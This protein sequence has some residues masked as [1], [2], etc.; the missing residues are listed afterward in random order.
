MPIGNIP[1]KH[2]YSRQDF[3]PRDGNRYHAAMRLKQ[4]RKAKGLSQAEIADMIGVNQSTISKMENG[5]PGCTID[6]FQAYAAALGVTLS[7][8][9]ADDREAAES[10]L[11]SAFRGLSADRQKGWLDMA[12]AVRDGAQ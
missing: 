1:V 7:E 12:K 8:L 3:A 6:K 4:I 2:E 9:F 10:I 11:V 5:D